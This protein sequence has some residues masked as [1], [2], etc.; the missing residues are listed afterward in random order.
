MTIPELEATPAELFARQQKWLQD[1]R[2]F[3]RALAIL[4]LVIATLGVSNTLSMNVAER[5]GEIGLLRAIGWRRGRIARL[6]VFEG[7]LLALAGAAV[8]LPAASFLLSVLSKRDYLGV[9]PAR[10]PLAATIEGIGTLLL[11]G[12][13]AALPPLVHA[14][15]IRPA[16]ALREL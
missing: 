12:L 14:L 1:L 10:L 13:V 9:L 15:R 8:G 11:A 6:V 3:G 4:A 7:L 2:Q 16:Q 5:T